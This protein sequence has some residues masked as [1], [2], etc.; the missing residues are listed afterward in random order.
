MEIHICLCRKEENLSNGFHLFQE[1]LFLFFQDSSRLSVF[2][3][4]FISFLPCA[5]KKLSIVPNLISNPFDGLLQNT[6][7]QLALPNNDDIPPQSL[8]LPPYFLV[9]FFVPS[10][11]SHPEFRVCFRYRV[12]LTV[13]MTMPKAT[14]YKDNSSIFWK[15]YI[16]P[17]RKT[18]VIYPVATTLT[19]KGLT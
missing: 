16:R 8:Q 10:N 15:H 11:L 9:P 1:R 17:S 14:M 18:L 2:F 13:C 3:S 7:F 4:C 19:P 6:L 12:I 5:A